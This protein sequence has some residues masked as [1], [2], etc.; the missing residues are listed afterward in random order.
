[1]E[2]LFHSGCITRSGGP[3]QPR[4]PMFVRSALGILRDQRRVLRQQLAELKEAHEWLDQDLRIARAVYQ[5]RRRRGIAAD[6]PTEAETR[7]EASAARI[8]VLEGQVDD[9]SRSILLLMDELAAA[10]A[11]ADNANGAA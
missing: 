9:V 5:A 3:P 7:F 8:R 4:E 1:M 2:E 6:W 10:E 11:E